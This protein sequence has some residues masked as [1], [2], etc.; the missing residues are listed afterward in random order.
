MAELQIYPDREGRTKPIKATVENGSEVIEGEHVVL[1]FDNNKCIHARFC[2]MEAPET[3]LA[4]ID[5]PWLYPDDTEPD[6][7]Y[8]IGREC[9]S[10][11]IS[12]ARKDGGCEEKAPQV[13]IL[14]VR[15]N[16]PLAFNGDLTIN[17]ED[18]GF[19]R[20][21]CRCGKSEKKPYCDGSHGPAGF[22]ASGERA[23][24]DTNMPPERSGQID[25]RPQPN[26]PLMVSGHLEICGGTGTLI[27]RT[28]SCRLCRCG[29]S[30]NKPFCDGSHARIGFR[31][32]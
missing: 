20:T 13:N 32:E 30:A 29:A 9:P 18:A 19:R 23:A 31:A 5:G 11:A 21:L 26:G 25:I 10:G 17:G 15:E 27:E 6:L 2:V 1:T 12:I 8:A 14:R 7:L 22:E 28:D 3:F 4:N 24:R 16:G